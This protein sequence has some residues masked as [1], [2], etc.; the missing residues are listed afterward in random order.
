MRAAGNYWQARASIAC[1]QPQNATP[2]FRQAARADETFYG[3]LARAALGVADVTDPAANDV[4]AAWRH[5]GRRDNVRL[6]A[7]LIEIGQED[8]A[9]AALRRQARIAGTADYDDLIVLA[10]ALGLPRVQ[11]WLGANLPAGAV[12]RSAARFPRTRL[13]AGRWVGGSA[14]AWSSPTLCKN[15]TSAT[16]CA[17]PPT[18]AG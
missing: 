8:A 2:L 18:R 7:S 5:L 10:G 16:R 12:V 11:M 3:L 4:A 1:G 9:D 15:R 6:A 13:D 14:A 17:P